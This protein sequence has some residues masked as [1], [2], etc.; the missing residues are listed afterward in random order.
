MERYFRKVNDSY[1][2][3]EKAFIFLTIDG[4]EPESDQDTLNYIS[5]DYGLVRTITEIILSV[6]KDS[7]SNRVKYYIED[8]LLVLNRYIMKEHESVKLAQELYKNHR[9]AIDFIIENKPSF[10]TDSSD[11][12]RTGPAGPA[13]S[14]ETFSPTPTMICRPAER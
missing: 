6:Y 1:P 2:D 4:I 11:A 12:K 7:L 5:I 14:N 10:K 9:V 13:L 8:Y 3:I